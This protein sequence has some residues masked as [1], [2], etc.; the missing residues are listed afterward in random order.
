MPSRPARP[1]CRRSPRGTH[2]FAWP[3]PNPPPAE[4]KERY[5]EPATDSSISGTD[6]APEP[7]GGANNARA[8][9]PPSLET[10]WMGCLA[11]SESASPVRTVVVLL[12]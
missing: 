6:A 3:P 11:A 2:L 4:T 8:D 12:V 9:S 10:E 5:V 1:R 7:N